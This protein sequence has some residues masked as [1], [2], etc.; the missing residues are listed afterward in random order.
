MGEKEITIPMQE[1]KELLETK[2]KYEELCRIRM[3]ETYKPSIKEKKYDWQPNE[4]GWKIT[5]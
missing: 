5:C 4:F 1:Y 3:V 2:G